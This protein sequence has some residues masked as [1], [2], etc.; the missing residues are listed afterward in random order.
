MRDCRASTVSGQAQRSEESCF[1]RPSIHTESW[2]G[3]GGGREMTRYLMWCCRVYYFILVVRYLLCVCVERDGEVQQQ[4]PLFNPLDERLQTQNISIWTETQCG[5]S[6]SAQVVS[7]NIFRHS[8]PVL[9]AQS[10]FMASCGPFP[11]S[12]WT[13]CSVD[14][15]MGGPE[16]FLL[17]KMESTRKLLEDD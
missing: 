11:H 4:L 3:G 14:L 10:Q 15:S 1:W 12:Y 6:A 8:V 2:G 9:E 17:K 7:Q 5:L 13:C 16:R